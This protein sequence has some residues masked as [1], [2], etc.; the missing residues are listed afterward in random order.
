MRAVPATSLRQKSVITYCSVLGDKAS[1]RPAVVLVI[2]FGSVISCLLKIREGFPSPSPLTLPFPLTF[3]VSLSLSHSL[4]LPLSLSFSL[5][6]GRQSRSAPRY[7]P[8]QSAALALGSCS[9]AGAR[10]TRAGQPGG[11]RSSAADSAQ[12]RRIITPLRGRRVGPAVGWG[13]ADPRDPCV[14]SRGPADL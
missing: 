5:L 3:S 2:F 12:N 13:T 8:G 11:R 6:P 10:T 4:P 7:V 14:T 1:M 9:V